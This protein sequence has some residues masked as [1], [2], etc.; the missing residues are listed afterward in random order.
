MCFLILVIMTFQIFFCKKCFLIKFEVFL[1]CKIACKWNLFP[2][3]LLYCIERNTEQLDE[4][5]FVRIDLWRNKYEQHS[6]GAVS[7]SISKMCI[8]TA[9][10]RFELQR[11]AVNLCENTTIAPF[12]PAWMS[13]RNIVGFFFW[14]YKETCSKAIEGV[15]I[16]S[17]WWWNVKKRAMLGVSVPIYII[18]VFQKN[19]FLTPFL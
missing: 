8:C 4:P 9:S 2:Q 17:K 10:P 15:G 16:T 14:R 12:F 7:V 19:N 11:Y 1:N 13:Y 5:V 18:H 3:F 6:E